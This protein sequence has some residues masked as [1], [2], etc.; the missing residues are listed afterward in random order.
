ML[1]DHISGKAAVG[2]FEVRDNLFYAHGKIYIPNDPE[3]KK[4]LIS[5]GYTPFEL[6]TGKEV[7][8]PLA[9]ATGDV[10]AQDLECEEFLQQWQTRMQRAKQSL[11]QSKVRIAKY[12][13]QKRRPAE[14]LQEEL[15]SCKSLPGGH[16]S[17]DIFECTRFWLSMSS[18]REV[19]ELLVPHMIARRILLS[20]KIEPPVAAPHAG[21]QKRADNKA[22]NLSVVITLCVIAFV[23]TKIL[24]GVLLYWR[25]AKSRK[26]CEVRV[27][28]GKMVMFRSPGKSTPSTKLVLKKT[29][30][31][32]NSDI[33]GSGGYGVVYRLV[34][35]ENNAFAVKK[36]PRGN[37]DQ[38]RGFERE[39]ETLSDIKHRNIVSLR[40]YY[41]ASHVNLLIYDLMLNGSLESVLY[42]RNSEAPFEWPLRLNVAI[43]SARGIAYLHHDC[44]PHIIH[45]DIKSSN[46]LLDEDLEP[47]V[48]D[49][50]L[51]N[52]LEA[53]K[54]HATTVIAGTLGYL[55]PEYVETGKAT[56]QGD[57]Y[58]FG[59]VL[60]ELVT[61]Q[62]P[63][64]DAF[65][66]KGLNLVTWVR[67]LLENGSIEDAFDDELRDSSYEE[68][69][70]E[71]VKMLERVIME[72]DDGIDEGVGG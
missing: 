16:F 29:Q 72:S 45:R 47:H 56:R 68:E 3:L 67:S 2:L 28:G 26:I 63:T 21:V 15:Q 69:L 25:W 12:A 13:N 60:L 20:G 33:I 39:I 22:F 10:H 23:T 62:R 8:T 40:G 14:L 38:E 36:L 17:S 48:S 42:D 46:I 61:G 41:T 59:V 71:V 7:I 50:G 54:T 58:S 6:S 52:L 37:H 1:H 27:S 55:A 18:E 11:E 66:E 5:T 34:V 43:G 35:D 57:V 31:L 32:S 30:S 53:D 65:V 9:L 64:D 4:D 70:K 24:L 44:I 51:A 49:F 19:I